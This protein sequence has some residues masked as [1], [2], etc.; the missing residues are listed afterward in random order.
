MKRIVLGLASLLALAL[1]V[2]LIAFF[3]QITGFF[4]PGGVKDALPAI[5]NL[6]SP[7]AEKISS[8]SIGGIPYVIGRID[9]EFGVS[10]ELFSKAVKEAEDIW[11][12]TAD[13]D[14][15]KATASPSAVSVSLV[16]DERQAETLDLKRR[17]ENITSAEEKYE[18]MKSE[19]QELAAR[20]APMLGE[21]DSLKERHSLMEEDLYITVNLY[22]NRR[23]AYEEKVIYW[24]SRGGAPAYEYEQLSREKKEIDILFAQISA[25]DAEFKALGEDINGKVYAYNELAGQINMV[26]GMM[27]RFAE[28]LNA[29]IASYNRVSAD[30]EEFVTGIYRTEGDS[31]AI[32]VY[33][34][35][36]YRDLV[37]I[38]AHEMGHAL[39]LPHGESENSIMYSRIKSQEPKL[40]SEDVSLLKSACAK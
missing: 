27:N 36:D 38:L 35:Y 30:R 32:E 39:G 26:A 34:F 6:V 25:K 21:I 2:G 3:P 7:S 23:K 18:A 33:Q 17:L 22:E 1:I 24:N 4:F 10:K 13:I 31:R 11:E 37:I 16:F 14:I 15:F 12:T 5:Q 20:M 40:S 9:P 28:S 19:Y 8:C 29:G